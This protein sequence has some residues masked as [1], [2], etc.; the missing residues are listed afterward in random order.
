MVRP[1]RMDND[2]ACVGTRVAVRL[3]WL[4]LA[5]LLCA[6]VLADGLTLPYSALF[7]LEFLGDG[8]SAPLSAV[9]AEPVKR[10]LPPPVGR[11]LSADLYLSLAV[12]RSPGLVLVHGL[13][14]LG[15]DEPRLAQAARL[16]A[17]AGWA[18]AVPTVDGLTRLRLR[19]EDAAPV[20]A[21]VEALRTARHVPVSV[22]AVSLGGGPALLAATDA[23]PLDLAAVLVLG[24]YASAP[25]LLRYTLTGAYRFE[26]EGGRS[27]PNE[28]SIAL[29][30]RAN[31]EL[32]DAAGQRLVDNRDP[33][34]VDALLAA[35]PPPTRELLGELSPGDRI[36]RLRAPLFRVHG[37]ADPAVPFTESLPVLPLE[38]A[39]D[40]RLLESLPGV[41]QGER[42]SAGLARAPPGALVQGQVEG[43]SSSRITGRVASATLRA[44]C[45]PARAR[46]PAT[47]SR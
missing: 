46:C 28:E 14:P 38:D 30:A 8:R 17:R 40:V 44:M 34:A 16:L 15:K 3:A 12:R 41:L 29:F 9:S 32:V 43:R 33:A 36:G 19:P 10:S 5:V 1:A 24:G 27:V 37:R 7:L 20:V 2:L 26:G 6:V 31:V 25:E 13:A 11:N 23:A 47:R 35:L 4:V 45:S 21:A 42:R 22:L 18:V 39:Q